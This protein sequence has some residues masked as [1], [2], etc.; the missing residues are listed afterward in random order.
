MDQLIFVYNDNSGD[1]SDTNQSVA[2]MKDV[3]HDIDIWTFHRLC[4][5]FAVAM[6]F[7]Q[8]LVD[9]VFGQDNWQ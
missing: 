4:K 2:F 3:P 1:D 5:A 9:D 8:S 6:T 7:P